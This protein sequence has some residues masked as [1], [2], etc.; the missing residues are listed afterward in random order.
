MGQENRSMTYGCY[1]QM[2]G[3][4]VNL[5]PERLGDNLNCEIGYIQTD[6]IRRYLKQGRLNPNTWITE[7]EIQDKGKSDSLGKSLTILQLSWLLVQ[8]SARLVPRLPLTTLELG[9][10]AYIP[11][12]LVIYY[13]WWDKPYE[14]NTPT[15]L[16]LHPIGTF[17]TKNSSSASYISPKSSQ[18]SVSSTVLDGRA[19]E[20]RHSLSRTRGTSLSNKVSSTN[21]KTDHPEACASLH[22]LGLCPSNI[23]T[24]RTYGMIRQ[25]F[26]VN[27][28][29]ETYSHACV[30]NAIFFLMGAVHLSGWDF[31]FRTTYERAAWRICSVIITVSI[32]LAW[33]INRIVDPNSEYTLR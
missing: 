18:G 11:C 21:I 29:F 3:F 17:T 2:G 16:D 4:A 31:S 20:S 30:T 15:Y 7:Q 5:I 27:D 19:A 14:I 13:L 22:E 28:S 32:P 9:T 26:E 33:L 1:A 25:Y 12:A 8:C 23:Q 24:Y 6:S 10:L